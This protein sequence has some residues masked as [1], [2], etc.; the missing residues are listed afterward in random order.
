MFRKDILCIFFEHLHIDN[1]GNYFIELNGEVYYIDVEDTPF[2]VTAVYRTESPQNGYE[3]IEILLSDDCME[4]LDMSSLT[5]GKDN[6]LY[7]RIKNGRFAARFVR[8]SYYQIAEF[9]QEDDDGENFC[10]VLNNQKYLIVN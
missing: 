7:C 3:Q 9:I 6:V 5:I 1:E 4:I 10:I 2:V 8:K